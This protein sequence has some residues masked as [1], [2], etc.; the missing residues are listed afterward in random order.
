MALFVRA[1]ILMAYH[2][3]VVLSRRALELMFS[4]RISEFCICALSVFFFQH[5]SV[6][7]LVLV[8]TVQVSIIFLPREY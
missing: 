6:D 5:L 2:S 4:I 1:P 7:L 3:N 8:M